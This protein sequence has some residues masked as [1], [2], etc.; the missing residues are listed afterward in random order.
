MSEPTIYSK[1]WFDKQKK[2]AYTSAEIILPI[3][4]D[5]VSPKSAVDVGCGLGMWL[6][7]FSKNGVEDIWGID[8]DYVDTEQLH[9]PKDCF[10][11]MDIAKPFH[12]Q[13]KADLAICLEVGEH[14][15]ESASDGLVHSL[16]EIAP[17]VLFS[18]AIPYQPGTNHINGQW[19]EFWATLFKKYGYI[20][21]DCIR[22]R[23]WT[24]TAV[25]YWYAQNSIL[26]VKESDLAHYPKLKQEV[27]FGYSSALP[28][29]HPR[30]YHYALKPAPTIFFR[31]KRKIKH[32]VSKVGKSQ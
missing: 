24:N 4:I 25:E 14:L 9:I 10:V 22:R 6:E 2:G 21:V 13:K 5:F 11:M 16:T 30:R 27:D 29:V 26:Y 3:V 8:G 20:P 12:A 18:A 32:L 15:P 19:P 7:V 17:V 1:E 23:V 31:I 28:L